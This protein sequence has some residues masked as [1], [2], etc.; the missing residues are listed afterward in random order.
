MPAQIRHIAIKV[1]D[2]E[3]EKAFYQDAF[4]MKLCRQSKT[5]DHVS[6]HL[7][8]GY[9]DVALVAYDDGDD[10]VE[11]KFAPKGPCIHHVGFETDDVDGSVAEMEAEGYRVLSDPGVIPVKMTAP[12]QAVVEF[13]HTGYFQKTIAQADAD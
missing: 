9:I 7:T 3:K 1:D 8:D 13:A 12:G 6:C 4:G 2:L 11:A 10:S 5:R